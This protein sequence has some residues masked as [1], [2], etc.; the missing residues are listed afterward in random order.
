MYTFHPVS[1]NVNAL[2]NCDS[3]VKIRIN[4][5]TLLLTKVLTWFGFHLFSH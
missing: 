3:F 2:H 4:I 1:P 5:G